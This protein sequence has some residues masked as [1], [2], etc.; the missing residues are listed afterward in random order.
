MLLRGLPL[1]SERRGKAK[2]MQ[3]ERKEGFTDIIEKK[4]KEKGRKE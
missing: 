1:G 4:Q 2:S 3:T